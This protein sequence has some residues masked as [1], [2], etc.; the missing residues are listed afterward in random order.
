MHCWS[1]PLIKSKA[2]SID[3]E[4]TDVA[5]WLVERGVAAF[6]LRYRLIP[7]G[8]DGVREMFEKMSQ[9]EEME[10]EFAEILPLSVA[11][12]QAAVAT[13]SEPAWRSMAVA[14]SR[15]CRCLGVR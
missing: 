9:P 8:E 15:R 5:K 1:S 14:R 10:K 4:G 13:A 12:G 6:V 7:T 2:I 11:D 3:T